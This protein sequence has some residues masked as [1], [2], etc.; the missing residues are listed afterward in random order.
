MSSLTF[1]DSKISKY[2]EW[3]SNNIKSREDYWRKCVPVTLRM[4]EDFPELVRV[5]GHYHDYLYPQ[6]HWWLRT[7]S[8]TIVDPTYKQFNGCG[9]NDELSGPHEL[10]EE[11]DEENVPTGKC[12]NCGDYCYDNKFCCSEN[13]YSEY[14]VYCMG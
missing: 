13:C 5:R 8:G 14:R 3:I 6:P 12:P 1:Q 11:I 2:K 7:E 4:K 10:Y 9:E